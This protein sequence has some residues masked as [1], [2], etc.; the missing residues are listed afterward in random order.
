MAGVV[1]LHGEE[2]LCF[3]TLVLRCEKN[4]MT[5]RTGMN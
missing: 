5:D 4:R 1:G 3:E 2:Q